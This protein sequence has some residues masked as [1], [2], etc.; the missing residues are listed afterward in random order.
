MRYLIQFHLP[1]RNLYKLTLVTLGAPLTFIFNE[2]R[3]TLVRSLMNCLRSLARIDYIIDHKAA[4]RF[5]RHMLA[6]YSTPLRLCV[7]R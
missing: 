7:F 5:H 2:R 1:D 4:R 6:M 3:N